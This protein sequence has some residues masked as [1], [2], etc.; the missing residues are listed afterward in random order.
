MKILYLH[1]GMPKTGTSSIQ[2]TLFANRENL[3]KYGIYYPDI[4]PQKP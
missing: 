3:R 2:D 1:I 4:L